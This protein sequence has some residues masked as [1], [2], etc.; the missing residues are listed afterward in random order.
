MEPGL[1]HQTPRT[2]ETS[3]SVI[4]EHPISSSESVGT[5]SKE[6]QIGLG[7][8]IITVS[9]PGFA[10]VRVLTTRSATAGASDATG[11]RRQ[12]DCPHRRPRRTRSPEISIAWSCVETQQKENWITSRTEKLPKRKR[13]RL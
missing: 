6:I 3:R 9:L 10:S 11:S 8:T 1:G 7:S 12:Q 4:F 5:L 2:T 13:L